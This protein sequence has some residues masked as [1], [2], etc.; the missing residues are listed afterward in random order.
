MR[1]GNDPYGAQ[2]NGCVSGA[3]LPAHKQASAYLTHKQANAYLTHKQESAYLTH[4]QAS[5]LSVGTNTTY[6]PA[7][8]SA[9]LARAAWDSVPPGILR[10]PTPIRRGT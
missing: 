6:G 8:S 7:P 9:W 4:K 10:V 3:N 2:T 5:S 1:V